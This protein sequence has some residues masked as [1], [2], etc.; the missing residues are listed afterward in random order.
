MVHL[1]GIGILLLANLTAEIIPVNRPDIFIDE[2]RSLFFLTQNPLLETLKVDHAHGS[3][4]MT[5]NNQGVFLI[6][7]V[8]PANTAL[9]LIRIALQLIKVIQ[10]LYLQRLFQLLLVQFLRAHL[11][12][13]TSEILDPKPNSS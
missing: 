7:V 5:R 11:V 13:I 9:D 3:R 4:A 2:T 1:E 6:I 12:K 8:V 10:C